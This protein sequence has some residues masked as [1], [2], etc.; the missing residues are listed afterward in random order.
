MLWWVVIASIL[1]SEKR[2]DIP[3]DGVSGRRYHGPSA[4]YLR[5]CSRQCPDGTERRPHLAGPLDVVMYKRFS[6]VRW[7]VPSRNSRAV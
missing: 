7:I 1:H 2:A 6:E 4:R 5:D 3:K